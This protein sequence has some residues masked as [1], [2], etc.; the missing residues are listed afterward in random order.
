MIEISSTTTGYRK[1]GRA[2]EDVNSGKESSC[3]TADGSDSKAVELL[4]CGETKWLCAGNRHVR[5]LCL[6][7]IVRLR[8]FAKRYFQ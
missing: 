2:P 3:R 6:S 4:D 1:V 7:K 8:A 5:C